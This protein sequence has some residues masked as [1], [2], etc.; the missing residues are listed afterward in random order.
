MGWGAGGGRFVCFTFEQT[1]LRLFPQFRG[2]K[3]FLAYLVRN[4]EGPAHKVSLI[5]PGD[6]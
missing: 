3:S 1:L 2:K 4:Q 6:I 5:E